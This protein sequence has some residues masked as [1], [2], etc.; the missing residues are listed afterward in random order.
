M[1]P[2]CASPPTISQMS[3]SVSWPS[4]R[5]T[6]TLM[7]AFHG[8]APPSSGSLTPLVSTFTVLTDL[9]MAPVMFSML[10]VC[11]CVVPKSFCKMP[12]CFC[13]LPKSFYKMPKCFWSLTPACPH[14]V[15]LVLA[16]TRAS[17]KNSGG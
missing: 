8:C 12:K 2:H 7:T 5:P 17:L 10:R 6:T 16:Q 13:V 11:F 9:S 3:S 15:G 4:S 1:R 14:S